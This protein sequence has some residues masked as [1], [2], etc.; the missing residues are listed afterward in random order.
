MQYYLIHLVSY[1]KLLSMFLK[2]LQRLLLLELLFQ[3]FLYPMF[4][5]HLVLTFCDQKTLLRSYNINK[6]AQ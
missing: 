3:L 4:L 2:L 6:Y 5:W 1:T